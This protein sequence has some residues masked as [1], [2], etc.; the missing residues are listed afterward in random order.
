MSNWAWTL[1][2]GAVTLAA[3]ISVILWQAFKHLDLKIERLVD[4]I[5]D[6]RSYFDKKFDDQRNYFDKKFDQVMDGIAE[7]TRLVAG[8]DAQIKAQE[9]QIDLL[10]AAVFGSQQFSAPGR[11]QDGEHAPEP[12]VQPV[13]PAAAAAPGE[14]TAASAGGPEPTPPPAAI[15]PA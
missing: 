1:I 7:I 4:K 10:S 11:R 12:A 9:K 15:A 8:H 14:G 3:A 6:Q 5:D 13:P 2:G